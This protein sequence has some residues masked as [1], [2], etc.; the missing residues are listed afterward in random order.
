MRLISV[1][2]VA[3]VATAIHPQEAPVE[4]SEEASPQT[5]ETKTIRL[6]T[7]G[8]SF[9]QN[10]KKFLPRIVS[11]VP[12]CQLELAGADIGGG[13]LDQHY[14]LAMESE[15]D[16][17][18]RPY[19]Y[20][21]GDSKKANLRDALSDREW[22][23]VTMQQ[24]SWYS[25][26]RETF[27]P[28]FDNIHS[29]IQKHAPQAEI[30]IHQT[31]AY[32]ADDGLFRS[33]T[34]SQD[35]MYRLLTENYMHFAEEYGCPILPVGKAFQLCRQQQT[36]KFAFPDP[37]YDFE[38]PEGGTLPEQVG[39]LC[40]GWRWTKEEKLIM[41]G[42]HANDRGCYLAGCVWFERL[43]GVDAREITFVPESL[44]EQDAEF[45]RRIAH[46]AVSSQ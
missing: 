8:N 36:P 22:D 39:S 28:H 25:F 35:E 12:G 7:V 1:V 21:I 33:E 30:Y 27:T 6:L 29:Y 41:D 4:K 20:R 37:D 2:F 45:L 11:S 32:R 13:P 19:W 38:N 26:K 3:L 9:A 34:M 5:R 43:F 46:D 40:T 15:T 14:K 24:Y 10:A 18:V 16:L 44:D 42:H 23:V 17:E 31:W